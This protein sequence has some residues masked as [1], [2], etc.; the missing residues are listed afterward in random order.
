[1]I[2]YIVIPAAVALAAY[3]YRVVRSRRA[4]V[5]DEE[6]AITLDYASSE[7]VHL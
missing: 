7:A 5:D 4:G 6:L 3:L 1:M 2:I